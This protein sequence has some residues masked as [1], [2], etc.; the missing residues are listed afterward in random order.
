MP[1]CLL[2]LDQGTHASRAVLF[3]LSGRVL[4]RRVEPLHS[5]AP[6]PGWVEQDP[7]EI[8]LGSLRAARGALADARA[9]AGDVAAVGIANQRETLVVWEAETGRAV[10]PALVWQDRRGQ[11]LCRELAEAATAAD[12]A[13]RTG[14]RLDPY[15][16]ATKLLWL[17]RARPELAA[18][19]RA[20]R[21]RAG[22]VDSWLIHRLTVG[23]R[24]ATD[25]SNASRTLLYDL[26]RQAFSP[27][28]CDLF[29]VPPAM[30]PEV[31]P[32][33]GSFGVTAA[34]ELGIRARI[35][36]V[37]GDQQ[38]ALLGQGCL[39]AGE[40]KDTFGT[41][42]FLLASAGPRRPTSRHGLLTTVA[43]DF[44]AGPAYAL[45]GSAFMA[46][47][48]LDWLVDLGL[49]RSPADL[50]RLACETPP[51]HGVVVLP[52]H[53]GLGAPWWQADVRGAIWGLTLASGRGAVARAALEA[54]AHQAADLADAMAADMGRPLGA[55][56]IDGG[57]A[58]SQLLPQLISDLTGLRVLRSRDHE[59]TARGAAFAA[60]IGAGL[61]Q[62]ADVSAFGG[63]RDA[64]E[65]SLAAAA[66]GG[67]RQR[68]RAA[69]G[70]LG[71]LPS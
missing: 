11:D 69:V 59:A 18:A 61:L 70:A 33:A 14:L 52:A 12:L 1:D 4:A 44:G 60:G 65:P 51:G 45:E 16:T 37:L 5:Q 29:E 58:R 71:A 43:W 32:S 13:V 20:G 31:L 66:R 54:I 9:A 28:L 24:F 21:L 47:A 50:D 2:A 48:L 6:A 19:A 34:A 27:D 8:W 57:V 39:D 49:A 26:D 35:T 55:L 68:W 63:D 38:A 40:A 23:G 7:E 56:R 30:L 22:T 62:P 17:L 15:F 36:G 53:Q 64:F 46:G 25:P 10:A 41:G 67:E 42:A 3:D